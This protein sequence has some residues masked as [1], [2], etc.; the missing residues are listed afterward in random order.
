[1]VE[2]HGG[3][4]LNPFCHV[5]LHFFNRKIGGFWEAKSDGFAGVEAAG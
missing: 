5:R 3:A 1:M 4:L 2:H